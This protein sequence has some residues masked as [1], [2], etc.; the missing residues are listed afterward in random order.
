MAYED[1]EDT[2]RYLLDS[3]G[4]MRQKAGR[5]FALLDRESTPVHFCWV[6]DF[7]GF[8]MRDL[9][10]AVERAQPECCDNF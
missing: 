9:K 2:L 7:E 4:R 8:E 1:E 10:H 6:G 5:G 3:A